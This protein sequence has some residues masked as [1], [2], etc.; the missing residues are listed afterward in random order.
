MSVLDRATPAAIRAKHTAA[1]LY[2]ESLCKQREGATGR[3]VVRLDK[4][5]EGARKAVEKLAKRL[6]KSDHETKS[7]TY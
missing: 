1:T 3:G 5:I 4:Q 7:N 6:E 2:L